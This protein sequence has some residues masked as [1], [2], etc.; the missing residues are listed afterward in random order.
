M[1]RLV[2]RQSLFHE[3]VD[4][5][6]IQGTHDWNELAQWTDAIK[7]TRLKPIDG[8]SKNMKD[9]IFKLLEKHPWNRPKRVGEMFLLDYFASELMARQYE[10]IEAELRE[11]RTK[12]PE[13]ASETKFSSRTLLMS[14]CNKGAEL[15]RNNMSV[16]EYYPHD[17]SLDAMESEVN[18]LCDCFECAEAQAQALQVIGSHDHSKRTLELAQKLKSFK[19]KCCEDQTYFYGHKERVSEEI[20]RL[21]GEIQACRQ[22]M[23]E[24]NLWYYGCNPLPSH[25]QPYKLAPP[26]WDPSS[27]SNFQ[28][29]LCQRCQNLCLDWSSIS[30]DMHYILHEPASEKECHNG[31]RDKGRAGMRLDNFMESPTAK[32]YHTLTKSEVAAIRFYTSHSYPSINSHLR[33]NVNPKDNKLGPHPFRSI[34]ENIINGVKKL[35]A[36]KSDADSTKILWRGLSNVSLTNDFRGGTEDA[37]MSTSSDFKVALQYS[38]KSGMADNILFRIVTAN[39]NQRGAEIQWL[40]MFPAESEF[41]YPPFTYLHADRNVPVKHIK[42]SKMSFRVVTVSSDTTT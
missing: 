5:N 31:I 34:V 25:V 28:Q 41:L 36:S 30:R 15:L 29:P 14:D 19:N 37:F 39:N 3:T 6:L 24:N 11:I 21:Y 33:K 32:A 8:N 16:P 4:D 20:K 13:A 27:T 17:L 7:H 26:N 12:Q 2:S 18:A 35:R 38:I 9:L 10:E 40:S 42:Q 23:E 1:F 22:K